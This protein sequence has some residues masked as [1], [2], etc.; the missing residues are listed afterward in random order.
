MQTPEP[1]ID[2]LSKYKKSIRRQWKPA[3]IVFIGIIVITAFMA[4]S[5]KPIYSAEGKLFFRREAT[6]PALTGLGKDIGSISSL[7]DQ[8]SPVDTEVE[9][10]RSHEIISKTLDILNLKDSKGEAV[11]LE[12]FSKSIKITATK[13]TDLIQVS[14]EY[15]DPKIA[16][17]VVNTFMQVYLDF[18][19]ERYRATASKALHFIEQEIPSAEAKVKQAEL[20]LSYFREKNSVV[21]LEEEQ[22]S[23]VLSIFN[24]Q[25]EIKTAQTQLAETEQQLLVL[26]KKLNRSPDQALSTNNISQSKGVQDILVEKQKLESQLA[27]ESTRY[28]DSHPII[29]SLRS[30]INA[31]ETL[32]NK[33]IDLAQTNQIEG[34]LENTQ[35]P[36]MQKELV[37]QL[38]QLDIRREGLGSQLSSLIDAEAKSK[39]RID[40]LPKIERAQREL[41]RNLNA[42]QLTYTNLRTK[43]D[44]L[45]IAENQDTGNASILSQALAP[46]S[47]SGPS[48]SLSMI[49][50]ALFGGIMAIATAIFFD[51]RD[52]AL[53]NTEDAIQAYRFR[54]L[55]EV[56]MEK[57]Y[58]V[59]ALDGNSKMLSA[60]EN[61][62]GKDQ[63]LLIR[64]ASQILG[65]NLKVLNINQSTKIITVTSVEDQ[66]GKSTIAAYLA[67]SLAQL[68]EKVVLIDA[69]LHR[70]TQ[71]H[72]WYFDNH[73]GL[74]DILLNGVETD[75]AMVESMPNL[76]LLSSGAAS[77]SHP[78][79]ILDT[80]KMELLIRNLSS[81]Y[82]YVI[83]DT[84]SIRSSPDALFLS[85]FSDGMLLVIRPH[86]STLD[87]VTYLQECLVQ[88]GQ[89]VF[90]QV[91]NGV[92]VNTKADL[93]DNSSKKAEKT[94]KE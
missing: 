50:G 55:G 44:E 21:S 30:Q 3:T 41:L 16:A 59:I 19:A 61:I 87:S 74:S 10:L 65:L 86:V 85:K 25:N 60:S 2:L 18:A 53:R 7:R 77:T 90:A 5:K 49:A 88:S 1:S 22:R 36:S 78:L 23:S 38:V 73:L 81:K 14:Y 63:N 33:R 91:V 32:L 48:T 26:S 24:L 6:T 72:L 31:T 9:V 39:Q 11:S 84:P 79:A 17:N 92:K 35:A 66:E 68:G 67:A 76:S 34:L 52:K 58:Q 69:N 15:K 93:Q 37:A 80:S 62:S 13:G 28:Q 42:A 54:L 46:K 83:L 4:I 40:S 51:S 43:A 12:S 47:S 71:H 82:D 27:L 20:E 57:N 94:K 45:R 56:P 89:T 29:Q 8:V 75:L 64:D 70:S